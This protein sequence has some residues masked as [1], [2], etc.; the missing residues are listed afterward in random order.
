[1]RFWKAFAWL[2]VLCVLLSGCNAPAGGGED[3]GDNAPENLE[4]DMKKDPVVTT[5]EKIIN[6]ATHFDYSPTDAAIP[7]RYY[8]PADYSEEYAYPVLLFLHG[9]GERGSDNEAQLKNVMQLL[10]NDPDSPVYQSIVIA[11]Q[12][13]SDTQWVNTPWAEGSYSVDAVE[14]TQNLKNVLEVLDSFCNT[15]SV[16]KERVY[17]MGLSMGGFGTW[18]LIMRHGELFKAAIPICGGA[19]PSKADRLVNMPIATF[20]GDADR[21]VPVEG[22]R[23]IVEAI[24]DAGGQNIQYEEIAGGGHNVWDHAASQKELIRWLYEQ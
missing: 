5:Q 22:T 2:M 10:F 6:V 17:V 3:P 24:R 4:E 7:Y 20:H 23:E 21:S 8:V 19:D 11:P 15:Y 14:E 13:P 18:D 9:A 12:C 16:N 1:M